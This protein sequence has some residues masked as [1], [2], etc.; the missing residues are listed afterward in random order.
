MISNKTLQVGD[1]VAIIEGDARNSEGVIS[2][3]TGDFASV[4]LEPSGP[5][6]T[7][8][9][10]QLRRNFK[11][12]DEVIVDAGS[13]R[14]SRGWV[15]AVNRG[16]VSVFDCDKLEEIQ[17]PSHFIKFSKF[18]HTLNPRLPPQNRLEPLWKGRNDRLIGR[19]LKVIS[20]HILKGYEGK[21]KYADLTDFVDVEIEARSQKV[22]RIHLSNL[23]YLTNLNF[24]P[25]EAHPLPSMSG[26][27]GPDI[28]PS[29]RPLLPSVPL[30]S[31]MT[32]FATS[33]GNRLSNSWLHLPFLQNKRISVEIKGTRPILN[34]MGW[35]NGIY[36][37]RSGLCHG[38]S[39]SLATIVFGIHD[40]LEIP[41][42][43]V[44]PVQP[45]TKGLLVVVLNG[46]HIGKEFV[47]I[48]PGKIQCGVSPRRKGSIRGADNNYFY[49]L[50]TKYLATITPQ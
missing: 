34:E 40:K 25:P 38:T 18:P 5:L 30:P 35:K 48:S 32:K 19:H 24:H 3:L 31:S 26:F 9:R 50:P 22:E 11:L 44:H 21:S 23:A 2:S 41:H 20:S 36:E 45:S 16:I 8:L 49:F 33:A 1:S 37:G 27:T 39:N 15:L 43:Y 6:I 28:P 12:G 47:V 10:V 13:Q 14:N 4:Y 17:V 42:Q 7:L 46:E 29:S